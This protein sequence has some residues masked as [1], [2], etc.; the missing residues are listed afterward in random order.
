MYLKLAWRNI[1]RNRSRTF[2][3]LTAV[4]IAVILSV[5]MMSAKNGIYDNMIKS[6]IGD[7]TGFAQIHANGY[8]EDKNI[9][10]VLEF[11]ASI[12]KQLE[13][14]NLVDGYSPRLE[15][16]ALV[17]SDSTTKGA[18]VIGADPEKE[19]QYN[20]L[21]NRVIEGDYLEKNDDQIMVGAGLANYLKV[22]VGDTLVLLSQGYHGASAAGKYAIKGIVKFG[23]PELS[24]QLVFLSIKEA[25]L[26][27]GVENMFTN[28]I[29]HLHDN[30]DAKLVAKQLEP[31]LGE[32]YE[33]M[34]W[35]ELAPD[36]KNM[37]AT[38]KMEGYI[39][40]FILYMVIS[41]GLF[42]TMLMMLSER[43]HEFGVLIA[44]GMKRLRLAIIV[45]LELVI[46]SVLG[47]ITGCVLAFPICAYY[48]YNPIQFGGEMADIYEEYGI[49]AVMQFSIEPSIFIQQTVIILIL[50]SVIAIFPFI[51]IQRLDAIKQMR[52]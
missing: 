22:D 25:Q 6:L 42:G 39:F 49:E 18:M 44:I 9:D 24:N 19:K 33:V 43:K 50:S 14:D 12:N 40:M 51:R 15:S 11:N 20:S 5:L 45:W 36:L 13:D 41:F 46:I 32:N 29:L 31:L 7:F 52:A 27:Y 34:A 23:S 8:W 4:S 2:I 16:F 35:E 37:I 1:W 3:T 48:H 26:F 17:V 38:D 21:N 10:N 28:I 30:E 47:A